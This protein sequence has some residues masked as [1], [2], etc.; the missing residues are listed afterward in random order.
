MFTGDLIDSCSTQR[1][2]LLQNVL[3]FVYLNYSYYENIYFHKN[4]CLVIIVSSKRV[5]YE[6][7]LKGFKYFKS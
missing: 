7:I 4:K 5:D 3:F 6:N 2:Y 1:L